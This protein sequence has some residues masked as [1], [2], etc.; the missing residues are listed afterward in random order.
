MPRFEDPRLPAPMPA[1]IPQ[2]VPP[3]S[4]G[5]QTPNIAFRKFLAYV[6]AAI[7]VGLLIRAADEYD[8]SL[9]Y[10]AAGVVVLGVLIVD[11]EATRGLGEA[12][13][14]L[15]S[16]GGWGAGWKPQ[17]TGGGSGSGGK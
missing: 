9:A 13:K 17:S 11:P 4:G 8:R 2:P 16:T 12:A 14:N 10:L 5:G 15:Q 7:V 6:A 3:G 1:G